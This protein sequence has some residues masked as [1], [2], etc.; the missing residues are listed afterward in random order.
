MARYLEVDWFR[1]VIDMWREEV[2]YKPKISMDSL[3]CRLE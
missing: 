2:D 3:A 1:E